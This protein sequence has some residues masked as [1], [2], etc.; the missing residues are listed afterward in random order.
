LRP[1]DFF[2]FVFLRK[3]SDSGSSQEKIKL[4]PLSG[5]HQS[6]ADGSKIMGG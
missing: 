3:K 5:T 1:E 2:F 4:V 6:A